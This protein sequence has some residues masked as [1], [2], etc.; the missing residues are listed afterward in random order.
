MTGLSIRKARR[1]DIPNLITL[2]S[3]S[4]FDQY[5]EHLPAEC[6]QRFQEENPAAAMIEVHW[7]HCLV[8]LNNQRVVGLILCR[9]NVIEE[10]WVDAKEKRR[11]VGTALIHHA[12]K[13]LRKRGFSSLF[14]EF[15]ETDPRLQKFYCSLGFGRFTQTETTA[16]PSM[17]RSAR[18]YGKPL[19]PE[20]SIR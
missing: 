17:T 14:V 12:E 8:A 16:L 20:M 19:S 2:V 6:L 3:K 18:R 9:D 1:S 13:S 7:P 11:G 10:L 5:A 15:T 4:F